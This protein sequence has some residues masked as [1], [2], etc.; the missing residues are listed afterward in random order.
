MKTVDIAQSLSLEI[1][2]GDP[3]R[4]VTGC[5]AG[6]L[7]SWVMS[8][9]HQDEV[10]LTIMSN[11]NVVAVAS[12]VDVACVILAENVMPDADVLSLAAQKDVCI[13]RSGRSVFELSAMLAKVLGMRF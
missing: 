4:E 10:W 5:Y 1:L 13:L 9:A 6:D 11:A 2:C 8:H 3:G 12:L 7:L